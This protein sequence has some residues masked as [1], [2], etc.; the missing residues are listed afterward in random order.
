MLPI[1][2]DID[3]TLTDAPAARWGNP[4]EKAIARLRALISRGAQAV[5]WSAAGGEYARQFGEKYGIK[6]VAFLGKPSLIVDDLRTLRSPGLI[7][8]MSPE[9][10]VKEP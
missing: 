1:Y 10:F 6:A 4:N 3:G 5:L 9:E 7:R 8:W 2:C